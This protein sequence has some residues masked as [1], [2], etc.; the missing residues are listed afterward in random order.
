MSELINLLQSNPLYKEQITSIVETYS[1]CMFSNDIKNN[2]ILYDI[3][4]T[5][6]PITIHFTNGKKVIASKPILVEIS[7]YFKSVFESVNDPHIELNLNDIITRIVLES[8]YVDTISLVLNVT[9]II[10]ILTTRDFLLIS[11]HTEEIL[12]FMSNNIKEICNYHEWNLHQHI[13]IENILNNISDE[14]YQKNVNDIIRTLSQGVES[15]IDNIFVFNRWQL[16]TFNKIIQQIVVHK[17]YH[18]LEKSGFRAY[19]VI[20]FFI[21]HEHDTDFYYNITQKIYDTKD[22]ILMDKNKPFDYISVYSY[23]PVFMYKKYEYCSFHITDSNPGTSIRV[24]ATST[25]KT[26][27]VGDTIYVRILNNAS[28]FLVTSIEKIIDDK[29]IVVN[30]TSPMCFSNIKIYYILHFNKTI[31]LEIINSP[32]F[33][34]TNYEH[35]VNL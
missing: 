15:G 27:S 2:M 21:Q 31:T 4:R 14:K 23:Y 30:K 24:L 8:C 11:L 32:W 3:Y 5:V 29:V 9:N 28:S 34:I 16:F 6:D 17:A 20:Q 13:F 12:L 19:N 33:L 10:D 35:T 26:I 22:T 25:L 7:D 18:N 1:H